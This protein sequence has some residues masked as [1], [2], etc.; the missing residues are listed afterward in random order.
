M[1]DVPQDTNAQKASDTIKE[2]TVE[3]YTFKVDTDLIDDVDALDII[4]EIED[5]NRVSAIKPLL[6]FLIG[7][8]EYE[9]MKAHFIKLDAE[10]NKDVKD[11]RPRFR[12]GML[13][14]IYTEIIANFDPKD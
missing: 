2:L 6:H 5:K 11:Y 13:G 9:K 7:D 14:K 8:A 12:A 3:G 1:A 4:H 10:A